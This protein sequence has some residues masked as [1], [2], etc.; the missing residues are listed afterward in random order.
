MP[1]QSLDNKE[2]EQ[3]SIEVRKYP[4]FLLNQMHD[5]RRMVWSKMRGKKLI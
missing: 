1:R 4:V 3:L 5:T 2:D